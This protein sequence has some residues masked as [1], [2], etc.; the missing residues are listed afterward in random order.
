MKK[1]DKLAVLFILIIGLVTLLILMFVLSGVSAENKYSSTSKKLKVINPIN[2]DFELLPFIT[3]KTSSYNIYCP[4]S[5]GIDSDEDGVYDLCDNCPIHY[6]PEQLDRDRDKKGDICDSSASSS[7][8]SDNDDDDDDNGDDNGDDEIICK[9]D[10]E[11]GTNSF[12]GNAFCSQNNKKVLQTFR[13]FSCNN[14][15]T[16]DS[17]CSSSLENKTIETCSNICSNGVCIPLE[18]PICGN[19]IVETGEQCDDGNLLNN[20]GC[21]SICEIEQVDIECSSNEQ[22]N[23]YNSLTYDEC[24]NPGEPTS[25]CKNTPIACASASDCGN[26]ILLEPFCSQN[27]ILQTT[28]SWLCLNAGQLNAE[29]KQK[30]ITETINSCFYA[31]SDGECNRCDENS[32]CNDN[33]A[34]TIDTCLFPDT[35]I[36]ECINTPI[37][38][39]TPNQIRSCGVSSVGQCTLGTETCQSNGQWGS[40]QGAILPQTETCDNL[41]NNCNGLT[42]EG[43]V[44]PQPPVCTNECTLGASRCTNGGVQACG[45]T[46][47]DSCTEWLTPLS[48]GF[49]K[50][51]TGGQ[52]VLI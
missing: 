22:C 49:G 51:C 23:D 11:C 21:S 35:S 44:C 39:C 41:D 15:D 32:D 12:I 2:N 43:N 29:C 5:D 6:N 10:N 1:S 47:L 8:S 19:N 4:F 38:V 33:N 20:D 50:I 17:E 3:P 42:D 31:C 25:F 18:E 27:N 45:N 46:D 24:K 9:E 13:S 28:N 40:C 16:K 37:G 30:S 26:N 34:N 14:P 48:C 36:S 7:S 52:C